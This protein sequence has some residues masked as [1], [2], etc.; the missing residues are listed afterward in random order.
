MPFLAAFDL[1]TFERPRI[2]HIAEAALATEP[3]MITSAANP[4]SAGGPHDFSSEGDDWWP[5]PAHRGGP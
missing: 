5:D 3:R 2:L 4:R 1:R